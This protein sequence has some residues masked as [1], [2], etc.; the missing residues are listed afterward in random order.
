MPLRLALPVPADGHHRAAIRNATLPFVKFEDTP[1]ATGPPTAKC[2]PPAPDPV[3]MLATAAT[4]G[5]FIAAVIAAAATPKTE[6][7]TV[8]VCVC[9][10]IADGARHIRAT[11]KFTAPA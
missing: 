10:R 7:A 9:A 4:N 11:P 3:G 5:I 8:C 1:A 6:D 2:T